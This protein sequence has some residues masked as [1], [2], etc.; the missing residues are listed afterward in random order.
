M[1]WILAGAGVL[2][3]FKLLKGNTTLPNSQNVVQSMVCGPG[4]FTYPVATYKQIADALEAAFAVTSFTEDDSAIAQ[5]LMLMQNDCDVAAL[6]NAFGVR[7]GTLLT[8]D[9]NLVQGVQMYLDDSEKDTVNANY[10]SKGISF[11]W[12]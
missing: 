6:M 12:V 2:L 7:R 8:D 11:Y 9:Y 1:K 5:G 4:N 10:A 3:L